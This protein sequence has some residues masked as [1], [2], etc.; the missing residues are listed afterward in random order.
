VRLDTREEQAQLAAAKADAELAQLDLDRNQK[1]AS[2]GVASQEARDQAQAQR[3]SAVAQ[4]ERLQAV[5]DKKI[6]RAPFDGTAGIYS[7]EVGEYLQANTLITR[8][9]GK[10]QQ[11]WL[12]FN[13]P[14]Q[15]LDLQLG[16]SINVQPQ[17]ATD[18]PIAASIIAKDTR[19]N[20]RSGNLRYRAIADNPDGR[21]FPGTVVTV[22]V[23]AAEPQTVTRV[24]MT[25]VR[26]DAFGANVYVLEPAEPGAAAEFRAL[27][28]V[29]TLGPESGQ[30]V[31]IKSGLHA[32]E[33][34]AGNGA[35]KLREGILV[36][37]VPP[38]KP[39]S[40]QQATPQ[41]LPE[42][43]PAGDHFDKDT[44]AAAIQ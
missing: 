5:I 16:D 33:K 35:F 43:E 2:R 4:E 18:K 39:V 41:Q 15:Q 36:N 24:P 40:A 22:S 14:Q 38:K 28:R 27:R 25:A 12:E 23:P 44:T 29:V 6:I 1:L 34:V 11:I 32:G 19:V 3:N 8:L 13:L 17:A 30:M 31:V 26:Y 10:Q 42:P 7:L 21:L 37:T 9:V 20:P